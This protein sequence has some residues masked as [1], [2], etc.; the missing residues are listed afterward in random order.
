MS[1]EQMKVIESSDELKPELCDQIIQ[2]V[3]T[4][5][6]IYGELVMTN[7][8]EEVAEANPYISYS[9]DEIQRH[10]IKMMSL[11]IFDGYQ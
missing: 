1:S 7:V 2:A 6:D 8:L 5:Y 9:D 11:E 10:L 4:V 3:E